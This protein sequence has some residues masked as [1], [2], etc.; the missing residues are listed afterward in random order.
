MAPRPFQLHARKEIVTTETIARPVTSFSDRELAEAEAALWRKAGFTA[1]VVDV[2]AGE[3]PSFD[4]VT[5]TDPGD[6]QGVAPEPDADADPDDDEPTT[7]GLV[8]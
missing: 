3:K 8:E 2:N 6:A 5:P 4:E 1:E 7:L